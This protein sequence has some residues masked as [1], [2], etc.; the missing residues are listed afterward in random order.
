MLYRYLKNVALEWLAFLPEDYDY[1]TTKAAFINRF[2]LHTINPA[3]AFNHV[4]Y[5]A[6]TGIQKYFEEKRRLGTLGKIPMNIMIDMMIDGLPYE[7]KT[8]FTALKV[9][10]L[11]EFFRIASIAE[12]NWKERQRGVVPLALPTSASS[13]SPQPST[14]G[15]KPKGKREEKGPKRAKY[16]CPICK[17]LG[18]PGRFHYTNEC[19]NKN[20]QN[21]S[22]AWKRKKPENNLN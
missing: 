2:G 10:D 5:D 13:S 11:S 3:V 14:S 18:Y 20:R 16:E 4:K 15:Y 19:R 1:S 8:V 17:K 7:I 21:N 6:A 9:N 22:Q 12:S